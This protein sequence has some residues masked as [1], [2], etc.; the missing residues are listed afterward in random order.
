MLGGAT[1]RACS[2]RPLSSPRTCS[3]CARYAGSLTD[4]LAS[5]HTP[6]VELRFGTSGRRGRVRD[7]S[8]LEIYINVLAELQYLQS[9]PTADG[10]IKRGD[11]FYVAH[12]LRPSSTVVVAAEENRGELCQAVIR[13]IEDAGMSPVNLGA[14][15]TP[16]LTWYALSQNCGS[17]MVTGS[18]IPF[19]LNGYKLNTSAGELLK[20]HEAPITAHVADVRERIYGQPF[21]ESFFD[22]RGMFREG[23]REL[24]RPF[25]EARLQ[26]MA[27]YTEFFGRT[28]EGRRV[29]VYQHSAI[30]RDMLPELLS[31][32]GA[33]VATCGRSETFVA[34]DTEAIG[35]EELATIQSFVHDESVFAVVSTDGDSDRPLVLGVEQG[36]VRF[37]SGDLVGMAVAKYL[38]ADAVV[39]P[40]SCNDAIDRS[41]LAPV[42][43]PKTRI[44]S[45][46]VIAG[47]QAALQKGRRAVCGW[48]AN[49]GFLLGSDITRKGHVLTALP[50]RDAMLPILAILS[51]ASE[52]GVPVCELFGRMPKRFSKAAL[53]RNF[54][55]E[56]GRRIVAALSPG[57]QSVE[58]LQRFFTPAL[59]F[60]GIERVD[61]TDGIRVYFSNGDVAHFRPSGNAD[62][63]RM[64][65]VADTQTRANEI[66][67]AGL[68]EPD[69]IVRRMERSL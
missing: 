21:G 63:F 40:I 16:A 6:P 39:V 19:D 42:L 67:A 50:T 33:D 58:T 30:G 41:D 62:E 7:L 49:G 37:Y 66:V 24:P 34:I 38:D 47:M 32:L 13:A 46:H 10:G 15:P 1:A 27:R 56:T 5:L 3:G 64:Y 23:H 65:A 60:P 52:L 36:R 61:Y 35:A 22:E 9:L 12:D 45:P 18:H 31:A 43:E 25:D 11:A 8:Q 14:I 51:A 57:E 69:G 54:P 29:L 53:L 20:E 68:A 44:G 4:L 55:R 28:L 26:Y 59:G 48:E 17:I 2:S